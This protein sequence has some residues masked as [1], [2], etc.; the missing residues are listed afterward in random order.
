[1]AVISIIL[2]IPG[3]ELVG[4]SISMLLECIEKEKDARMGA[5]GA[6]DSLAVNSGEIVRKNALIAMVTAGII[7][8]LGQTHYGAISGWVVHMEYGDGFQQFHRWV[9]SKRS[10]RRDSGD[11]D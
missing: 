7:V 9:K 11:R 5:S 4:I 1:M 2:V 3:I 8:A 10:R 6:G